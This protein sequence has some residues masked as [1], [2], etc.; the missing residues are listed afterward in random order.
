M[1]ND[2]VTHICLPTLGRLTIE[3]GKVGYLTPGESNPF[4]LRDTAPD[5]GLQ[6]YSN[7]S[8]QGFEL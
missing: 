1:K 5:L 3:N 4:C 2:A 7:S 6:S 8:D